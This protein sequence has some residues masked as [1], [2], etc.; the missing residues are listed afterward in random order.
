MHTHKL[1]DS[2]RTA[3]HCGG[4][5]FRGPVCL[6]SDVE[7]LWANLDGGVRIPV[8][9]PGPQRPEHQRQA[10]RE[11]AG[12]VFPQTELNGVDGSLNST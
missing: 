11:A 7:G 5:F 8:I 12:V 4:C 10:S 3:Q 9:D 2:E 6:V 1:K